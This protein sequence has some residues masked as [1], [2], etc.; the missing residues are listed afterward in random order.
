MR[1]EI[2]LDF[3]S[4]DRMARPKLHTFISNTTKNLFC[5][6]FYHCYR[7]TDFRLT[8]ILFD[9][10][11][12]FLLAFFFPFT[13]KLLHFFHWFQSQSIHFSLI[14]LQIS[15]YITATIERMCDNISLQTNSIIFFFK[16][17]FLCVW[18]LIVSPCCVPFIR[19]QS[20]MKI[21]FSCFR[22]CLRFSR[23]HD[24]NNLRSETL[25]LE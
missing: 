20:A 7:K 15:C 2:L 11:S 22:C 3:C 10:F 4:I 21:T 8:P 1:P 19:F 9:F 6:K 5:V 16:V 13:S 17:F 25:E 18:T 12:F 24:S 14:S 23:I